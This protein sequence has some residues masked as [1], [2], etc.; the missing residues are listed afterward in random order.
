VDK[1]VR[2]PKRKRSDLLHRFICAAA[3]SAILGATTIPPV[4]ADEPA[5]DCAALLGRIDATLKRVRIREAEHRKIMALRDKGK[6]AMAESGDCE[7]PLRQALEF[8]GG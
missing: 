2:A 5:E 1:S 3:L 4:G 7:T 8:L 6:A